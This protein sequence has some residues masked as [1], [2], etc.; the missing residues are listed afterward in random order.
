MKKN[1]LIVVF[2]IF[3]GYTTQPVTMRVA[4][5]MR[6]I[7][8]ISSDKLLERLVVLALQSSAAGSGARVEVVPIPADSDFKTAV[9]GCYAVVVLG[10]ARLI[11]GRLPI[12]ELHRQS[13]L[14]PQIYVVSWQI[15][16]QTVLGLLESGIDQYM[17]F[18]LSL[19]RLC[20]KLL[21]R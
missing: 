8:V 12:A 13:A 2:G 15:G 16:E 17:T 1:R 5:V 20:F 19:R 9:A 3:F 10:A 4:D 18:P 21:N 7:A 14:R 11:S 6:R